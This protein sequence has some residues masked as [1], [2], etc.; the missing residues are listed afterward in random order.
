MRHKNTPRLCR[1]KEVVSIQGTM[2]P[3]FSSGSGAIMIVIEHVKKL[4]EPTV[5]VLIEMKSWDHAVLISFAAMRVSITARCR[6]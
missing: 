6:W 4:F 5:N 3:K 1:C 2:H